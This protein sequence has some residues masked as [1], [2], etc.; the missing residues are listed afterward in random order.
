G[1]YISA[2]LDAF[3]I[4]PF[5]GEVADTAKLARAGM[6]VADV[7]HDAGKVI[8]AVKTVDAAD[9]V[10]DV[11]RCAFLAF[12]GHKYFSLQKFSFMVKYN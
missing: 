6:N 7:A 4:L 12:T 11:V 2:G 3:G 10:V 8:D 9:D 1:D 5:V